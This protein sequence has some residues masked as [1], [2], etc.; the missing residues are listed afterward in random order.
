MQLGAALNEIVDEISPVLI[1]IETTGIAE[2]GPIA[3]RLRTFGH[4]LE[5]IVTVVDAITFPG[6]SVSRQI[7]D[8]Q[9]RPAD[10][11]VLNRTNG[12]DKNRLN[13]IKGAIT[14]LNP[15]AHVVPTNYGQTDPQLL[16]SARASTRNEG[17]PEA[18]QLSSTG[19]HD[20]GAGLISTFSFTSNNTLDMDRFKVFLNQLPKEIIRA[21]GILL[22]GGGAAP[23]LFNYVCGRVDFR[24]LP[25]LKNPLATQAVFIREINDALNEK[26]TVQLRAVEIRC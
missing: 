16:F 13:E 25:E 19:H 18:E 10:F 23:V 26:I 3:G 20:H 9:I 14:K 22:R 17:A 21:K 1:I 2:P 11:L 7:V 4:N 5:S 24:D 15:R 12:V 6:E 8:N